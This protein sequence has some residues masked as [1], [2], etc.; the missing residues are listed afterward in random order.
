MSLEIAT[1]QHA[2]AKTITKRFVAFLVGFVILMTATIW[3]MHTFGA[4]AHAADLP[5]ITN[6][7]YTYDEDG[8]PTEIHVVGYSLDEVV[9]ATA[10]KT[11]YSGAWYDYFDLVITARTNTTMTIVIRGDLAYDSYNLLLLNDQGMGAEFGNAIV[12]KAPDPVINSVQQIAEVD[13]VITIRITGDKFKPETTMNGCGVTEGACYEATK[14][15]QTATQIDATVDTS[16]F[17]DDVYSLTMHTVNSAYINFSGNGFVVAHPPLTITADIQPNDDF[18]LTINGT[19]PDNIDYITV[20]GQRVD[21]ATVTANSLTATILAADVYSYGVFDLVFVKESGYEYSYPAAVK[22]MG[23]IPTITSVEQIP[24]DTDEI[25]V[26]LVGADFPTNMT[27][28]VNGE[29]V[30]YFYQAFTIT[31]DYVIIG[32]EGASFAPGTYDI[33]LTDQFNRSVTVPDAFVVPVKQPVITDTTYQRTW[34]GTFQVR[35]EGTNLQGATIT[36]E[37]QDITVIESD[38][39]HLIFDLPGTTPAGD[40]GITVGRAHASATTPITVDDIYAV[41]ISEV[42]I[43]IFDGR[44][45][46]NV[47]GSNYD[48]TTVFKLG[49]FVITPEAMGDDYIEAF[50][51]DDVPAGYYDVTAT[52]SD[53]QTATYADVRVERPA[54]TGVTFESFDDEVVATISGERFIDE[55][56][57]FNDAKTQSPIIF[58]GQALPLCEVDSPYTHQEYLD[59]GFQAELLSDQAPCYRMYDA[60]YN[61]IFTNYQA[62]VVLPADYDTTERGTVSVNG[63]GP[64]TFNQSNTPAPM[65]VTTVSPASIYSLATRYIT[66][67]GTNLTGATVTID[68]KNAEVIPAASSDTSITAFI[69]ENT[70]V[71]AV[72]VVVTGKSGGN[73]TN[74]GQVVTLTN[75]VTYLPT[76]T[77]TITGVAFSDVGG[78]KYLTVSGTNLVGA[79]DGTVPG[80]PPEHLHVVTRSL[81]KLGTTALPLCLEGTGLTMQDAL[82]QGLKAELM[83]DQPTCYFWFLDGQVA[84]TKTQ[85]VIYLKD[86]FDIAAPGAISVN[87]SPAFSFNTP[88]TQPSTPAPGIPSTPAGPVVPTVPPATEPIVKAPEEAA[89][90]PAATAPAT[91]EEPL[92][93]TEVTLTSGG[94]TLVEKQTLSSFPTFS[95]YAPAGS[96]VVITVHSDPVTCETIADANGR[97]TCTLDQELPNGNH[98]VAIAVVDPQG[99]VT[100][101][102]PYDFAVAN[103]NV[104]DVKEPGAAADVAS[105]DA[106]STFPWVWAVAGA[107]LVLILVGVLVARRRAHQ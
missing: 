85:A 47:Y 11:W 55:R 9:R 52:R 46:L 58:D 21:P 44:P 18:L 86:D 95:G 35:L 107:A 83:S 64:F 57:I 56:D 26:G 73:S 22:L 65:T 33:V 17:P 14:V 66:F 77:K 37:G 62:V 34:Y 31:S 12:K 79:L 15:S 87:S 78:R 7:S 45:L 43:Y 80:M 50:V 29:P 68:G 97:W 98:T 6:A 41:T 13:G 40:Y 10:Q 53:G 103:S 27:A 19:L 91:A 49:D 106:K 51:S 28:T 67:A 90:K 69:P 70:V 81:V 25:N 101:V 93:A 100:K 42:S 48:E 20:G 60:D 38:N 74:A 61:D 54:I 99:N 63:I 71:G 8:N 36:F 96:K 30:T 2:L 39:T 16:E 94:K 3:A 82:D 105:E 76:P 89:S 5:G 102:G 72:D 24:L 75:G 84:L 4:P 104:T 92:I 88:I 32:A 23:R 59:E 1:G